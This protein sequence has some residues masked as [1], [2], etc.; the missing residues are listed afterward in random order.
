M[1]SALLG[2]CNK[3]Q[4]AQQM[5]QT[6][7]SFTDADK[8]ASEEMKGRFGDLLR[9]GEEG[10]QRQLDMQAN[11]HAGAISYAPFLSLPHPNCMSLKRSIHVGHDW[12]IQK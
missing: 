10:K 7:G 5:W 1:R 6:L 8:L 11:G 3:L 9:Q 2:H 12:S 4:E